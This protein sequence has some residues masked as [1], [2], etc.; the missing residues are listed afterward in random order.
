MPSLEF[1]FVFRETIH[2]KRE[3]IS[4]DVQGF[5]LNDTP[6]PPL[7]PIRLHLFFLLAA[8]ILRSHSRIFRPKHGTLHAIPQ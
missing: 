6:H 8:H 3:R 4:I 5:S 7:L 1:S 2:N